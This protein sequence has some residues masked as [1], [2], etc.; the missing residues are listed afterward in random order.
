MNKLSIVNNLLIDVFFCK[1][2]FVRQDTDHFAI[3]VG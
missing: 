1:V 2:T 3:R